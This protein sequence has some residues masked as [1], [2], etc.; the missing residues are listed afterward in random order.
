MRMHLRWRLKPYSNMRVQLQFIIPFPDEDGN[1]VEHTLTSPPHLPPKAE[2]SHTYTLV[3][4]SGP[5][6]GEPHYDADSPMNSLLDVP[7]EGVNGRNLFAVFI[8]GVNVRNGSLQTVRYCELLIYTFL[9]QINLT[10]PGI[11]SL[12]RPTTVYSGRER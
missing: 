8:D 7:I 6:F 11:L 1:I 4:R 12:F 3:L 5:G 9:C 10:V 2:V